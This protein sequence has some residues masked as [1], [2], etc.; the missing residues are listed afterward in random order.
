M[1]ETLTPESTTGLSTTEAR[2]R[3]N[4]F[5]PNTIHEQPTP[6]WRVLLPKFWAPVPWLLEV[7]IVLQIGVGAY[8]EAAVVGALLVFNAVLGI[9]QEHRAGVALAALKQRLEPTALVCRD[10]QWT[11]VSAA[12]LVPGDAVQ[13][14]LGGVV[15]ADVRVTKGAVMADQSMLTGESVPVEVPL[16]GTVY[17]GSLVRR[18]QATG[19]VTATGAR[20][21]FGRT[22]E[23]VRIAHAPSSEQHA[24]LAA[25]K[26]LGLVN[27]I[28]ALVSVGYA[29][30]LGFPGAELIRLALT[31]LLATVP[32][33]LPA[34]FTLSAALSA[35]ALS[36][37]GALLTRLSAVHEAAAMDVLCSDKTGTLT[38]NAL[39]VAEISPMP[40]FDRERLLCLAAMASSRSGDDP[41]DA[42]VQLAAASLIAERPDQ[43]PTRFVPFDPE[44]KIAEAYLSHDGHEPMRVVKGALQAV[45]QIADVAPGARAKSDELAHQGHRIIAVAVGAMGSSMHLAGLI[46]LSD[47]PRTDSAELIGALKR[48]GVRTIMVTGDSAA[49]ASAIAGKVGLRSTPYPAAA[50]YHHTDLQQFDVYARVLPEEKYRLVAELQDS[51]HVVGMCGDGANDAP[52]LSQAQVGIAVSS[53]TDAAKAAAAVVLTEPGLAGIL[54]TIQE[55]RSAFRRLLAYALN[56]LVKKIEVVLLLAYGLVAVHRA[57]LTPMMMVLLLVTNDFLTMSLTTDRARPA[58]AP[59]IWHMRR[60][61]TAATI[62]GSCKLLF[63]GIIVTA[64]VLY[65]RLPISELQSLS[66]LAIAFGNQAV[67]YVLR[68]RGHLWHSLPSRWLLLSSVID[69]TIVSVLVLSGT[70]MA[71]LPLSLVGAV[72]MTAIGFALLLDQL[73]IPVEAVLRLG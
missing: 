59:S 31:A 55:G 64:G 10:G 22:V 8:V 68:E 40:G 37:R 12:D 11:R 44:T 9:V 23:L 42:A 27:G 6:Y 57:L 4:E 63:S 54:S 2:E 30:L 3:A 13:L 32:V 28:I 58:P 33:A 52:A 60:I 17:A 29:Y 45:E 62:F 34:T 43:E 49:T 5:G 14:A 53:A 36:R 1:E 16:G 35:L 73:K 20:T 72:T 48:L 70:L 47:P 21:Y 26:G 65:I 66:F 51:G 69:I 50:S 18:G 38:Q 41:L 67:L 46:A 25:V 39:E 7:S 15:P 19:V 71:A 24:V 56:M 61:V